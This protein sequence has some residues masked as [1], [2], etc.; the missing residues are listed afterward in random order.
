MSDLK[1]QLLDLH[2]ALLRVRDLQGEAEEATRQ[3]KRQQS[4]ATNAQ[5]KL[6]EHKDA[7]KHLRATVHEKEV[8]IK[9]NH[10]LIAKYQKQKQAASEQKQLDALTHQID[11]AKL[12]NSLLEE[13]ALEGLDKVDAM[14]ATTAQLEAALKEAQAGQAKFESETSAQLAD[15]EKRLAEAQ[16]RAKA[17]T[18]ALS[19]E[20]RKAYDR[21]IASLG[22]DALAPANRRSCTGC[23]QEVTS[24]QHNDLLSGRLVTCKS[25][26]RLLYEAAT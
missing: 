17:A 21:L 10:E 11:N 14:I 23:H 3:R 16:A 1:V 24:Q 13:S 19:P 6:D 26:N 20:V 7:L 15:Y 8:S 22:P 4:R 12:E 5:K 25:C 2:T 9:A 18:D